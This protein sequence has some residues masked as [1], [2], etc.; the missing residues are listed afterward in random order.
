[1]MALPAVH[2]LRT[3]LPAARIVAMARTAH[4][5]LA[6]RIAAFDHVVA[7]PAAGRPR[8]PARVA[9]GRGSAA[10]RAAAGRGAARAVVR[11]RADR[12]RGRDSGARRTCDG[13]ARAAADPARGGRRRKASV[14]WISRPGRR[15]RS[16]AGAGDRGARPATARARICGRPVPAGGDCGGGPAGAGQPGRGQDAPGLV[17]RPVLPPGGDHR[18]ACGRRAGARPPPRAVRS[19]GR[20]AGAPV[21]SPGRRGHAGAALRGHRALPA[22][23]GQ[24]QR[25]AA[26]R[27]RARTAPPSAST[28]RR[29]RTTRRRGAVPEPDTAPYRRVLPARPAGSGS[30]TSVRRRRRPTAGRRASTRCRWRPWPIRWTACCGPMEPLGLNPPAAP[31][32]PAPRRAVA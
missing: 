28:G 9:A 20:L 31:S 4:V 18:G 17:V 26:H 7:A 12:A 5:E 27:R 21:H 30:S 13:P 11:E 3:H 2:A 16:S 19:A 22:V 8:P 23:R 10:G 32:A 14:R 29:P 24:R 1:M 25:T 6:S 15:A